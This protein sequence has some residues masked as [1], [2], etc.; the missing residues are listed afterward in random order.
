[1]LL[2]AT[3]FAGDCGLSV[4][5]NT[6]SFFIAVLYSFI[7]FF[8]VRSIG[9]VRRRQW[10]PAPVL[11][12]GK[13]HGRRSLVG[14]CLWGRTESDNDWSDL[15]AVAAALEVLAMENG[16][17]SCDTWIPSYA[18]WDSVPWPGTE[19]GRPALGAESPNH[20]TTR[21]VPL[22]FFFYISSSNIWEEPLVSSFQGKHPYFL[23]PLFIQVSEGFTRLTAHFWMHS[24]L[25]VLQ[26]RNNFW[27]NAN[28]ETAY[29]MTCG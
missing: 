15:A 25:S 5:G 29:S 21:E 10:H 22:L 8:L 12:P 13:S 27:L 19:P 20:W 3:T 14:C 24:S 11:L 2:I 18:M 23:Q 9:S 16:I 6:W 26:N 28:L 4:K 7:R 17:F 1:M